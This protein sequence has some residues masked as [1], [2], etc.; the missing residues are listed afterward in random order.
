MVL[1]G[2]LSKKNYDW[3]CVVL[4]LGWKKFSTSTRPYGVPTPKL[5]LT[6]PNPSQGERLLPV[7][8]VL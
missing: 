8:V 3:R 1:L 6:I 5:A 7:D 4:E 2:V